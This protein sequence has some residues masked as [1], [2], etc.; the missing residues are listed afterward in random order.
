M[1]TYNPQ[2]EQKTG[3]DLSGIS[4]AEDRTYVLTNSDAI[5]ANM[6]ILID[7]TIL[8]PVTHF[9]LD[10]DTNTITFLSAVWDDQIISLDYWTES[11]ITITGT[12]YCTT[13]Q[14]ARFSGIGVEIQVEEL[15][16]GDDSEDSFD[17]D[18]GNILASSYSVQYGVSGS[19]DLSTM[20]ETTDYTI[21]KDDGRILL[22]AAGVTKLSTNKLY[23]SYTYSN[24]MSDTL[25][26]TYL[27]PAAREVEKI[28]TNYYGSVKTSIAY[29]DGYTSGYPQTERPFGNQLDDLPE[30]ELDM[31][32]VQSITSVEFLDRTGDVDSTVDSDYISLDE[33]G[34]VILTSS[35]VPN[36]KRNVKITYTHGYTSVP[37]QVQ[38]LAALI[39]GVMSLVNI[40]GGSYDDLT[41][42]TLSSFSAQIGEVYVNIR[43]VLSQLNKR[44]DKIKSNLGDNY[45]CA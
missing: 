43:E 23:I 39:G 41:S 40:S 14:I 37:A 33:D 30:F 12:A 16:T 32:S 18:N 31:Q 4:G 27:A 24:K 15:G 28:T 42:Y 44:I 19:N 29:F 3:A 6:Q 38:E 34:R 25:L 45:S 5:L 26:A 35:S 7:G 9:T 13:L 2:H 11:T 8:Q 36:G 21:Y 1:T 17:T 10:T 22:T 20:A